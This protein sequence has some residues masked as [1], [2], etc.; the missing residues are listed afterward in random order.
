MICWQLPVDVKCYR[1]LN[2]LKLYLDVC[3]K[4]SQ[5]TEREREGE[6]GRLIKLLAK[7]ALLLHQ[8]TSVIRESFKLWWDTRHNTWKRSQLMI[9][10][11]IL[12]KLKK[13]KQSSSSLA[14]FVFSWCVPTF[15]VTA[16]H[17]T[18]WSK[19][20]HTCS[21]HRPAVVRELSASQDFSNSLTSN[22][23]AG[24]H[25]NYFV[26]NWFLKED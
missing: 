6:R 16:Y 20:S 4:D 1:K 19:W 14:D 22:I 21:S 25:Y 5:P 15:W 13:Q 26:T 17:G 12:T 8:S 23:F 11:L 24:K 18:R 2:L 9:W 3:I 10:L 7:I